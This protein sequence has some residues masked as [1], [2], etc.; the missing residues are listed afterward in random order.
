MDLLISRGPFRELNAN[1]CHRRILICFSFILC[2]LHL[3]HVMLKRFWKCIGSILSFLKNNIEGKRCTNRLLRLT[4]F[5]RSGWHILDYL[6]L[7]FFFWFFSFFH[8]SIKGP[9]ATLSY[10]PSDFHLNWSCI[11][12]WRFNLGNEN[13]WLFYLK[14][15][16]CLFCLDDRLEIFMLQSKS[17]FQS[18]H[19][20]FCVF[21]WW[22]RILVLI[23]LTF[24]RQKL[25]NLFVLLTF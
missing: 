1:L 18:Q 17:N 5:L 13:L 19:I 20:I 24:L 25:F 10:V 11:W 9:C 3:S 22:L 21:L 7:L 4:R 16:H 14:W 12:Y 23:P 15:A 2:N 8:L 6:C